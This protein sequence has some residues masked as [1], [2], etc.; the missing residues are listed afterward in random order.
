VYPQAN[1]ALY[2]QRSCRPGDLALSG[3]FD[4]GQTAYVFYKSARLDT[5]TW[6]FLVGGPTQAN[7]RVSLSVVCADLTP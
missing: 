7:D 1:Q 2:A 6:E 3:G 5:D 4:G